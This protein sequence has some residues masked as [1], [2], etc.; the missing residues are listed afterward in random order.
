MDIFLQKLR[1]LFFEPIYTWYGNILDVG[2]VRM[3]LFIALMIGLCIIEFREL[4]DF[5][6]NWLFPEHLFLF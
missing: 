2:I 5:G 4:C 6:N 3:F 1:K